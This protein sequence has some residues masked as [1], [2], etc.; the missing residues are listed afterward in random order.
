MQGCYGKD[1]KKMEM[2]KALMVPD[3][4]VSERRAADEEVLEAEDS[5]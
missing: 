1:A 4:F 2:V 3:A 5:D